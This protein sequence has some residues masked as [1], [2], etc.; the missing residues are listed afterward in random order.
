L[1]TNIE[2][3]TREFRLL[4]CEIGRLDCRVITTE[5]RKHVHCIHMHHLFCNALVHVIYLAVSVR[6]HYQYLIWT[7]KFTNEADLSG[8]PFFFIKISQTL[9]LFK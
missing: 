4:N 5:Y 2:P 8:V 3:D 9:S 1:Y 7:F 6:I